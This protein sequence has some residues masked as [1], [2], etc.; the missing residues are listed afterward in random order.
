MEAVDVRP[1]VGRPYGRY[2]ATQAGALL[3]H[4]VTLDDLWT[5]ELQGATGRTLLED[6]VRTLEQLV[7]RM[8]RGLAEVG[9]HAYDV[10]LML[11]EAGDEVIDEAF[12]RIV[13]AEGAPPS[14]AD[15]LLPQLEDY[16]L[17]SAAITGCA[18]VEAKADD[19]AQLLREKL[20][21]ILG[22][23]EVP[24][25][26]FLMPFRCAALIA[27][28][29]AGTVSVIG[30][31]GPAGFVALGAMSQVGLGAF[32]WDKAECRMQMPTISLGRR[33]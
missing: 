12:R 26:D 29:G 27:L 8:E 1:E 17:R 11:D 23:R 32:G 10:R 9:G 16:E 31:G 22:G 20:T 2:V 5:A 3:Q 28:V 24:P 7:S 30:L 33:E 15:R 18:Y 19:E 6:D 14:L 4:L 13:D 25:G 21:V